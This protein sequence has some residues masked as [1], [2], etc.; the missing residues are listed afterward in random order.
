M[1]TVVDPDPGA[2]M[3]GGPKLA[4]MPGGKTAVPKSTW[5]LKEPE[6]ATVAFRVAL[7]P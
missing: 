3:E 5:E 7:A 1:V 4:V 6:T 2:G